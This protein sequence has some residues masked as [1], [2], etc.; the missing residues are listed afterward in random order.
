MEV[1]I[2]HDS[3]QVFSGKLYGKSRPNSCH[4]DVH[5]SLDFEINLGFNDLECDVVQDVP[6]RFT[7]D[8]VIQ[9]VSVKFFLFSAGQELDVFRLQHHD[10]IVTSSDV[11]LKVRCNYELSNRTV[12]NA[13]KLAV[14]EELRNQAEAENSVVT[15]PNVTLRVTNRLAQIQFLSFFLRNASPS[16][17]GTVL[18]SRPP[19]WGTRWRSGSRSWRGLAGVLARLLAEEALPGVVPMRSSSENWW[20]WTGWTPAK[21]YSLTAKVRAHMHK[22]MHDQRSHLDRFFHWSLHAAGCPTDYSI[23]G[24][25]REVNNSGQVLQA[26]FDA[27]KFPT[28]DVVQFRALVTPCIPR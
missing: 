22:P 2:G 19:R 13:A 21:S 11:G 28:S 25:L 8:V 3:C 6:G 26:D 23:M 1:I 9:V 20:P 27:F 10:R 15:S 14:A 24:V 5:N 17:T 7:T 12:S 4:V 16:C 18:T